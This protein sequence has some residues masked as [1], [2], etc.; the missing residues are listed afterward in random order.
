M[1][2]YAFA[3]FVRPLL[4]SVPFS[5]HLIV[6]RNAPPPPQTHSFIRTAF[7]IEIHLFCIF[8]TEIHFISFL[9][10]VSPPFSFGH[11]RI[12]QTKRKGD[13]NGIARLN[14]ITDIQEFI[15]Y[16]LLLIQFLLLLSS[17]ISGRFGFRPNIFFLVS[18][19]YVHFL[20]SF[21]ISICCFFPF[22]CDCLLSRYCFGG[23]HLLKSQFKMVL[24]A[25]VSF[26]YSVIVLR[27]RV[28]FKIGLY[29]FPFE[30]EVYE[31]LDGTHHGRANHPPSGRCRCTE[32]GYPLPFRFGTTEKIT[33]MK[34]SFIFT[35]TR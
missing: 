7:T 21:S 8:T 26:C 20:L 28:P 27:G 25:F 13:K 34:F 24:M 23:N 6:S 22:H 12:T 4:S 29:R 1:A 18:N 11:L 16:F 15:W 10:S 35:F 32:I 2:S 3:S 9:S 17:S 5:S 31:I 30:I 19:S 14:Q 33:Y